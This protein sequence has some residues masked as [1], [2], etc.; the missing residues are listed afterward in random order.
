MLK[1]GQNEQTHY[2]LDSDLKNYAF[3]IEFK[4]GE[5]YKEPYITR[6]LDRV[7]SV[8]ELKPATTSDGC[9]N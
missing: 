9:I 8:F 3:N 1:K 5:Y 2:F 7:S 6:V 4:D